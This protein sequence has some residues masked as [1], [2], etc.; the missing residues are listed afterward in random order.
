MSGSSAYGASARHRLCRAQRARV[1]TLC[2]SRLCTAHSARARNN[3]VCFARRFGFFCVDGQSRTSSVARTPRHTAVTPARCDHFTF[4]ECGAGGARRGTSREPPPKPAAQG[5][6]GRARAEAPLVARAPPVRKMCRMRGAPKPTGGATGRETTPGARTCLSA[7]LEQAGAR[8]VQGPGVH[9]PRRPPAGDEPPDAHAPT[10]HPCFWV[11]VGKS[12]A[13][14][15]RRTFTEDRAPVRVIRRAV[16]RK[17][18]L[19]GA[20]SGVGTRHAQ[21]GGRGGGEPRQAPPS[22]RA[23]STLRIHSA[24]LPGARRHVEAAARLPP[25]AQR[26]RAWQQTPAGGARRGREAGHR[27][28]EHR[29]ACGVGGCVACGR[30]RGSGLPPAGGREGVQ[31]SAGLQSPLVW[32]ASS[33]RHGRRGPHAKR[34]GGGRGRAVAGGVHLPMDPQRAVSAGVAPQRGRG[35]AACALCATGAG[36]AAAA[37]GACQSSRKKSALHWAIVSAGQVTACPMVLG[38]E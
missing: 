12:R 35:S 19:P 7:L 23:T 32:R 28:R 6:A 22:P 26:A 38:D 13:K 31:L 29:G 5:G 21:A 25:P 3:F 36:A 15:Q 27:Q 17:G 16:P 11:A 4:D 8:E 37:L 30:V 1:I 34:G 20:G 2:V 24:T 9:I 18:R 10:R 14:T 33:I